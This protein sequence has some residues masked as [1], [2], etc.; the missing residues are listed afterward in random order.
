MNIAHVRKSD[1]AKQPLEAQLPEVLAIA[2]QLAGDAIC[3]HGDIKPWALERQ[4][5]LDLKI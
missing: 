4:S 2:G 1:R 5:N 3:R